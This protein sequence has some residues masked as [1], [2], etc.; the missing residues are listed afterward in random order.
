MSQKTFTHKNPANAGRRHTIG[1]ALKT[2]A[3]LP[4]AALIKIPMAFAEDLPHVTDD[5]P[6][7]K[8]LKYVA[9][10]TTV[11]RPDKAGTP[12]DQ[13]TCANCQFLVGDDGEWRACQLFPGKSVHINGWCINWTLKT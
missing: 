8:A 13:Q 12:G 7:A 11:E 4:F 1:L 5:D 3:L 9:D 6:M 2:M 10:A